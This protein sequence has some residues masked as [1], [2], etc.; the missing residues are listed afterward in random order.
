MHAN[1]CPTCGILY[2]VTHG[3]TCRPE[4]EPEPAGRY[5][6]P[7][8]VRLCGIR[9]AGPVPAACTLALG[10]DGNHEDH[11]GAEEFGEILAWDEAR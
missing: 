5:A 9:Y 7:T 6:S 10:H 3:H 8:G 1:L 2:S 11:S 4:P